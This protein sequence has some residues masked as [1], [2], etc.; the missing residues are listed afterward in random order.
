M[1]EKVLFYASKI[2][3][4]KEIK[5]GEK[6]YP[7]LSNCILKS[8][9]N[10]CSGKGIEPTFGTEYEPET[11]KSTRVLVER[12]NGQF[13]QLN[14]NLSIYA[15]SLKNNNIDKDFILS[16]DATILNELKINNLYEYLQIMKNVELINDDYHSKHFYDVPFDNGDIIKKYFV[17]IIYEKDYKKR[18]NLIKN[19]QILLPNQDKLIKKIYKLIS[20]MNTEDALTFI[21]SIF[22]KKDNSL[23]YSLIKKETDK[24]S[25][26]S[27]IKSL[28]NK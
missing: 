15:I 11:G 8:A 28:L 16:N 4:L 3:D 27:K 14:C 24:N 10:I 25:L 19:I 12:Y 26:K 9:Y 23:D 17:K 13:E 7:K 2:Q 20:K 18:V 22:I 6:V 21:N 5:K 1:K